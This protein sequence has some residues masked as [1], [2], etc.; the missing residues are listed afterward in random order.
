MEPFLA[1]IA[2]ILTFA[3]SAGMTAG[4][5]AYVAHQ[6]LGASRHLIREYALMSALLIGGFIV[7]SIFAKK[8]RAPK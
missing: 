4:T 6:S 5:L 1:G 8:P 2:T 3:G 7:V